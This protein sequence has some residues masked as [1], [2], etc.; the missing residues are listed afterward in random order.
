[1]KGGGCRKIILFSGGGGG[2]SRHIFVKFK[3][4][5]NEFEFFQGKGVRTPPPTPVG[6]IFLLRMYVLENRWHIY[7]VLFYIYYINSFDK[8]AV[9]FEKQSYCDA[10]RCICNTD[11]PC[12][13]ILID[14]HYVLY[15]INKKAHIYDK[16]ILSETLIN[17]Q[18]YT[19][20]HN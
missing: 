19:L 8:C 14:H 6:C 17:T 15:K 11:S 3:C 13:Q 7:V 18:L 12:T 2:A 16:H 1:M 5:F 4:E 10:L 9:Y 20:M